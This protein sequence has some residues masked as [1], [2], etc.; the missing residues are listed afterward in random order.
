[1]I[2][3]QFCDT[4]PPM[5][6]GVGRVTLSYCQTLT[7]M[8]HE[9]YYIAPQSPNTDEVFGIPVIL[10]ASLKVPDASFF[11]GTAD[12]NAEVQVSAGLNVAH[13]SR[14]KTPLCFFKA[15]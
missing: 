15:A 7:A 9:A 2:I 10:S 11:Q 6:D 12:G 3:G 1:M 13:C 5:V 4:Y 14:I 8:G